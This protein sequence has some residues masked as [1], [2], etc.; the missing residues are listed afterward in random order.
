[1]INAFR[2]DGR[3]ALITG[4]DRGIGRAIAAGLAECGAT[5][6]VHSIA[7]SPVLDDTL[8]AV[9]AISARS[10]AVTGDLAQ[11]DAAA[12]LTDA[13]AAA[14]GPI[15]ILVINASVQ[16]RKPWAEITTEDALRQMQVNF[17]ASLQMIQ[18]VAP[19][20]KARKWGRILAIGSVQQRRPHS[21]MAV[22]AA[23][24]AA[25][26]NLVR[27]LAKQLAPDGITVNNLSP[28]IILT[29]RN[30]AA[31]GDEAYAQRILTWV[32]AGFFGEPQDCAGAAVLLCSDAGRYI[33]GA[34]FFIDGGM[35]L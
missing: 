6:V 5:V 11:P 19:G 10:A 15:D 31:L 13:A 2:L 34:D 26:E 27:N 32:P 29:E 12:K 21:E 18:A 9:Q 23:T 3:T 4:S 25:Q 1:M 24:K 28:G 35:A 16:I 33:T 7:P 8:R 30:Q 22:Y 14:A 17:H 20:M